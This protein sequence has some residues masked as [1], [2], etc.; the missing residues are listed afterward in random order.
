MEI[1]Y[2]RLEEICPYDKNPRNNADA[3]PLAKD[4]LTFSEVGGAITHCAL[5]SG[6][7]E[8]QVYNDINPMITG[9]F[10]DAVNGKYHDENRVITM[11]IV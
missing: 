3:V 7:W 5:L 4:L 10:M 11:K 9:L 1:V 2:K 8:S 6:K